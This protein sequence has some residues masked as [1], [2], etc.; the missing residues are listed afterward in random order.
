MN[1]NIQLL[2]QLRLSETLTIISKRAGD[3][4]SGLVC[5]WFAVPESNF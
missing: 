4:L 5:A 2:F 3:R 1:V